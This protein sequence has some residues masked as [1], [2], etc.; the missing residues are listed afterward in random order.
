MQELYKAIL[1]KKNCAYY[2]AKFESFDQQGPGL[3]AGWNWAAFL[4]AGFWALYRKMYGWFFAFW[5]IAIL[6]NMFE[7][8]GSLGLSALVILAPLIW[9]AIYANSLYHKNIK[10][11]IAAAQVWCN[12]ETILLEHLR[13]KGGVLTGVW[14]F[15]GIP[16][17]GIIAAILSPMFKHSDDMSEQRAKTESSAVMPWRGLTEDQIR[18]QFIEPS[19]NTGQIP[20]NEN[21][22]KF[23]GDLDRQDALLA[24][25]DRLLATDSKD[26]QIPDKKGHDLSVTESNLAS[27]I[28]K[29][30][31]GNL[32]AVRGIQDFYDELGKGT[33]KDRLH[34]QWR[35]ALLGSAEDQS[36]LG[37]C[38]ASGRCVPDA[39]SA[40]AWFQLA[41]EQGN[42]YAQYSMMKFY[43]LGYGV[44]QDYEQAV[45]WAMKSALQG[46]RRAQIY[47]GSSY[48][49]GR[50][51][52]LD[53]VKAHMWLN[54]AAIEGGPRAI[55]RRNEVAAE[56]TQ[57]ELLEAQRLATQWK[58]STK[59]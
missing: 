31:T 14:L 11:K 16:V 1:G 28:E 17:I 41:A 6:A 46:E 49:K 21:W 24:A 33:F 12:D 47:L 54:L 30:N 7:K 42:A 32:D 9:F 15:A 39:Q 36:A 20:A 37:E 44:P 19:P 5:G 56:M 50:G 53:R 22:S 25:I 40:R 8:S 35:A 26:K 29:A 51:V 38:I 59:R 48:A 27:Y 10:K 3:K 57:A 55:K 23:A 45:K 13:K 52:A 58:P 43:H 18:T 34:W 2:Q 4:G